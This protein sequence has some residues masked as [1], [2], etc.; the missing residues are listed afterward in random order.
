MNKPAEASRGPSP[1]DVVLRMLS[2]AWM[3]QAV[4]A[5]VH[6]DIAERLAAGP[7]S[8]SDLARE[9]GALPD[10]LGRL[11]R[12]LAS[13]GL[14]H[15]LPDG[16]YENTPTSSTL[17][18]GL[19]DGL[20]PVARMT[21]AEHSLGWSRFADCLTKETTAFELHFGAP[22]FGWY[23]SHDVESSNF[24]KAMQGYSASQV[25][26][27]AAAY[28]TSACHRIVDVGGGH[29]GLL[30]ALL[31]NAPHARGAVF[32]LEQ[33]LDAARA[34]GLH[35]DPR[36]DLVAGDF[37]KGMT[38]G[39]DL[40]VM[41]FILHDW[42]DDQC[43]TILTNIRKGLAPGGKVLV[44]EQ[45]VGGPNQPDPAKWMDLHMMA[46][47]GGRERTEEEYVSLFQRAGLRLSRATPTS[48]GLRLL[49]A[50]AA[51]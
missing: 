23:A 49:E 15:Q 9:C 29:G 51:K 44:A 35:H 34:A 24:N 47:P 36:V 33:G 7:R 3:T 45:I 8:A 4:C 38:P 31:A 27:L 1:H 22:I 20:G 42:S 10:R 46:M 30:M 40:Y 18:S 37:F 48:C 21:G 32:D 25:P 6:F 28:D 39:G 12:A 2:G 41:K 11:L 5:A 26:A 50:V 16:R 43:V 17:R 14:F 13:E 19:A